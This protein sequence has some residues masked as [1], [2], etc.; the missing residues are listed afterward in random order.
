MNASAENFEA[1]DRGAAVIKR[2]RQELRHTPAEQLELELRL[3]RNV[4]GKYV[5]GVTRE[6]MDAALRLLQSSAAIKSN[7]W[8]EHH[9]FFF[10]LGSGDAART[11]VEFDTSDLEMK[12]STVR[13]Q[14]VQHEVIDLPKTGHMLKL[15][16]NKEVPVPA[17]DIPTTV[18]T[19]HVRIKQRRR[20]T[21]G[22]NWAYDFS[23]AWAG[24]TKSDAEYAQQHKEESTSYELEIELACDEYVRTHTDRFVSESFLLKA[25]DLVNA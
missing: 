6:F 4:H 15:S 17:R 1:I 14:C 16:L 20:F 25:H 3:G 12:K 2:Y 8:R 19:T 9:D 13:K 5:P 24:K 21:Y 23:I 10:D 11:R 18:N 22:V 7:D